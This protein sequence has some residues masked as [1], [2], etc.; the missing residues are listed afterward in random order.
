MLV[1]GPPRTAAPA[2]APPGYITAASPSPGGHSVV[3]DR[4]S[5]SSLSGSGDVPS[6]LVVTVADK[7]YD[8]GDDFCWEGNEYGVGFTGPSAVG[9]NSNNNIAL[10]L[11]CLH[12]VVKATSYFSV[13][14]DSPLMCPESCAPY[15]PSV[16]LLRCLVL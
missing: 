1:K 8:L 14:Q 12:A 10:H 6:G 7:E 2:P 16:S 13:S 15:W 11:S 4:A 5:A 3:A 9:C